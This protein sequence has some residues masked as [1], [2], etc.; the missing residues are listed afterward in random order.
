MLTLV[1]HFSFVVL[2]YGSV[3]F[4]ALLKIIF[5]ILVSVNLHMNFRISQSNSGKSVNWYF[6]R[7]CVESAD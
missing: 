4:L 5:A 2:K 6:D 1:P 7:G 3:N